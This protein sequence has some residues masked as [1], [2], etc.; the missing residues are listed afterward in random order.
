MESPLETF[1]QLLY[2]LTEDKYIAI[3]IAI[4]VIFFLIHIFSLSQFKKRVKQIVE[5]NVK[6]FQKAFDLAE[7]GMLIMSDVNRV[8]YV[9]KSMKRLLG[10]E[11]DMADKAIE[12]NVNIKIK[13]N[14]ISLDQFLEEY[15]EKAKIKALCFSDICLQVETG[16][17]VPIHL[18]IDSI[19]MGSQKRDIYNVISIQDLRIVHE[20][21]RKELKHKLT[22]LP[23]QKQAILD[24]PKLYSHVH[25]EN[26]KIALALLKLDNF[27]HLRS[28]IGYEQS[29][30]VLIKFSKYLDTL[31]TELNVTVYHT[32]DNHFLLAISKLESLADIQKFVE[33]I[34]TEL[35][36][37]YKTDATNLHLTVSA[38]IS[39]FPES[40]ATR[41]LM[42]HAYKALYQA[43]K[44]G[45]GRIV[46][47]LPEKY[48]NKYDEL[49]LH[50]DM[51]KALENEEFEVYYQPIV[52]VGYNEIVAAEALIRWI[53]PKHGFIPPDVFI[54][55]MEQTGFIIKLGKYV[56]EQVLK[57][58][59]RW[60]LFN[61]KPIQ[62]SINLSMIE[63]NTGTFHQHVEQQLAH[64]K[65]DPE[66]I[67]FEITES[68]AM[69]SEEKAVKLINKLKKLGV[70]IS[71]DDF[72][73]GYTSFD[74]LKKFPADIIKIDKSLVD[75]I[76][77]KEEDQRIVHAMIDL[78]HT[79]GMEV[80]VE[81]VENKEMV[82]LLASYGCDYIQGYY[83]SKPLPVFEFQ[84]LI[85]E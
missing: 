68:T 8:L 4:L 28:V 33:Q 71:L 11:E 6:V 49:A 77:E 40:G 3:G 74:Y 64:H 76:L 41:N 84:K 85:R 46:I 70:G 30:A 37:F 48:S 1:E 29:N 55:L 63:V 35:G 9:N 32:F 62:V 2:P 34:Q 52:K 50:N 53:H 73:T 80:V 69:M 66:L 38:G 79:L 25:L 19:A 23:N 24:L 13:R 59:K 36:T 12:K 57:Q 20:R 17:E 65:V 31:L 51:Q 58:Q 22:G 27:V 54:G 81:G 78:G 7:E 67:K 16:E 26:K 39:V 45:D 83:F 61:F 18:T 42:D 75:H 43:Q 72:G 5:D 21:E 44:E 15:S 56:L 14:W 47:F 10:L 60:E 82:S